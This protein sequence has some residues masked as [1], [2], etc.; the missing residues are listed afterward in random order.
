MTKS[1]EHQEKR[2]A[3]RM[4]GSRSAGSGAFDR[5][6]DIRAATELWEAKWTGKKT[7]TVKAEVL[8][9][10]ISEAL[11]EGRTP[12]LGLELNGRNYVI[13]EEDDWVERSTSG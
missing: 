11:A 1:W 6:G 9:K 12:V 4:S 13:V 8:E 7:F 10:I 2:I 3:K 5:K